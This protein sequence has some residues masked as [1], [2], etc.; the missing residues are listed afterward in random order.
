MRSEGPETRIL[1]NVNAKSC[2]AACNLGG[3]AAVAGPK[4]VRSYNA[5]CC[6]NLSDV[7]SLRVSASK[8]SLALRRCSLISGQLASK[9]GRQ[10]AEKG[11][12]S[13][14]LPP[15]L[16]HRFPLMTFDLLLFFFLHSFTSVT[17]TRVRLSCQ[18]KN[19]G[20]G[21]ILPVVRGS[22]MDIQGSHL[23]GEL[24]LLQLPLFS[25]DMSFSLWLS[26]LNYIYIY[27]IKFLL[28]L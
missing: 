5:I 23:W 4:Y 26:V 20:H 17:H 16:T 6:V 21:M 27:I 1:Q 19:A 24:Q 8:S 7:T 9:E 28:S 13:P 22:Q 11:K 15:R 18:M 3:M 25:N 12:G 14:P 10:Q 2:N